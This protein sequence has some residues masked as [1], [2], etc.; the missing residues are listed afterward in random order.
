MQNNGKTLQIDVRNTLA[1]LTLNPNS[2]FML[3][4][5][6][7]HWGSNNQVGSEHHFDGRSFPAEV[8]VLYKFSAIDSV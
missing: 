4:H 5:L 8:S 2:R 3:D 7:F 6:H 1:S